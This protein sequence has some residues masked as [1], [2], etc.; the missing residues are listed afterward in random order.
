MC[1]HGIHMDNFARFEVV[2]VLWLR[3]KVFRDAIWCCL[4]SSS[5]PF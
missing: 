4:V 5:C 3:I 2:T 1:L